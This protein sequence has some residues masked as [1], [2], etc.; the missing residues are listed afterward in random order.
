M[1]FRSRLR[2]LKR[3]TAM[4]VEA[5]W[6]ALSGSLSWV[7]R[8]EAAHWTSPGDQRVLVLAPHPDDEAMGCAG[9]LALHARAGD[10]VCVAIAT[11][12]RRSQVVG[13]PDR[14][15]TLR[16]REARNA[17]A[18]MCAPRLEW[19][20]F[21]EGAWSV[22]DLTDRL[23]TLLWDV[24]PQIIYAPSRVDF[25]P[26]H[27][28]VAHA[29]ALALHE[30]GLESPQNPRVRVYQVQVPLT[31][32]VCNLV[33]DV[34]SV[35]EQYRAALQAY[36]SQQGSVHCAYR[37]RRYNARV[38]DSGAAAEAFWEMP[39]ARYW[40]LHGPPPGSWPNAFRGLRHFPLTDPLAYLAGGAERRRLL[41]LVAGAPD[42]AL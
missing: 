25:H 30:V 10:R 35:Q 16:Q 29:L 11:D 4:A 38:Y 32:M 5:L 14:M 33:A 18:A 7:V 13:D 2:P 6:S 24:A 40:E 8:P 28:K 23:R 3:S 31:A 19:F 20:G 41:S 15:A 1:S 22:S 37:L 12:G 34:S 17:A 42:H 39:V 9:T 26:E 27:F 21:P 36:R